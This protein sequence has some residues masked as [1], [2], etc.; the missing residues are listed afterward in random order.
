MDQI[1]PNLWIN[2]GKIEEAVD[3]YCS[4]FQDSRV[5]SSSGHGPDAGELGRPEDGH[6]LR[7]AGAALRRRINGGDT[8]VRG[9]MRRCRLAIVATPSRRSTASGTRWSREASR[10][11]AAG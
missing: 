4:L 6:Q 11:R 10:D 3:F 2:D 9:Q 1:T 8:R 7:A 5:V